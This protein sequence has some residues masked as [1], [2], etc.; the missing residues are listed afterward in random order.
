VGNERGGRTAA[1][2]CSINST[3]RRH[4]IDPQLYLTQLL[5]NLPSTPMS[6]LEQWLP[7]VW[8]RRQAHGVGLGSQIKP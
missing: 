8:N 7:D 1:I 3:Y 5:I 4:D 2:L 6:R